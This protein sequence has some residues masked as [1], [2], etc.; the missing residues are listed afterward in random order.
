MFHMKNTYIW[1]ILGIFYYAYILV[2]YVIFHC[3]F[4]EIQRSETNKEGCVSKRAFTS[5]DD[6]DDDQ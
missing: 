2:I 1:Y 3:Y 5:D 4:C 6:D